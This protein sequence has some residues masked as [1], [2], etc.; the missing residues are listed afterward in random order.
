ML[1]LVVISVNNSI[2]KCF[3]LFLISENQSMNLRITNTVRSK[4]LKSTNC[5]LDRNHNQMFIV[6]FL[7]YLFLSMKAVTKL[8]GIKGQTLLNLFYFIL[9]SWC[10]SVF[11]AFYSWKFIRNWFVHKNSSV[12]Y[13]TKI[14]VLFPTYNTQYLRTSISETDTAAQCKVR[15]VLEQRR[16]QHLA[17]SQ[18][19]KSKRAHLPSCLLLFVWS[20]IYKGVCLPLVHTNMWF[21]FIL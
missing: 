16:V 20:C 15:L 12:Q 1:I 6:S 14:W 19:T 5:N 21:V 13:I 8:T 2:L 18:D 10:L 4:L 9:K 3:F 11:C 7:P 17:D